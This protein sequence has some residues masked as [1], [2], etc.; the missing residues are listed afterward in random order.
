MNSSK[1]VL[2][3]LAGVA[4][5]SVLGLLFASEKGSKTRQRILNSGEDLV[6]DLKER[7]DAVLENATSKIEAIYNRK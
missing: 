6:D 1:V 5:G 2:G 3:V 7:F 4:I